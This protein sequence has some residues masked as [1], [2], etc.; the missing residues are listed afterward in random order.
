MAS[1]TASPT[2]FMQGVALCNEW[3]LLVQSGATPAHSTTTADAVAQ[4]PP[5]PWA[6]N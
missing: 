4:A 3:P 5:P 1:Q 6:R 2:Q